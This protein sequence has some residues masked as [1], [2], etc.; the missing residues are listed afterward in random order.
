VTEASDPTARAV[1]LHERAIALRLGGDPLAAEAACREAVAL[2]ALHE[3]PQSPDLANALVEHARLLALLDRLDEGDS[4]VT[5]ALAILRPLCDPAPGAGH[6]GADHGGTD[7][8]GDAADD[9]VRLTVQGELVHASLLRGRGELA[10]AEAVGRRALALAEA[11]LPARDPVVGSALNDLGVIHKFRG[12]YAEAE[13]VYRRAL[14][15]IE[16]PED[17][18]DSASAAGVDADALATLYHNLGGLAHARGDFDAGEPLARRA[19]ELREAERGADHVQS[20][21]DRA[22]WGALLEGQG[23]FAEAEAAY[24]RA[25]A[26]FERQLGPECLEAAAA[27]ASL[28]SVRHARG[29]LAEAEGAYRR[30]LAI[31]EAALGPAHGDLGLTLHNLAVLLDERGQTAEAAAM[32]ER[33]RAMLAATLGEAHPWTR[34]AAASVAAINAGR[35]R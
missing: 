5:T 34:G 13:I 14:D 23:R 8:A 1:E 19:L 16:S 25:L 26:V 3:G 30:A 15:I 18:A 31:R 10:T 33:A 27:L 21:A 28:G 17:S 32:G 22:A 9:L 6:S 11:R 35:A 4:A 29:A 2:F 20:A 12:N 7:G 24:V